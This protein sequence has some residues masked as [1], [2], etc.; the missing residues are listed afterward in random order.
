M[1]N[2]KLKKWDI[3]AYLENRKK[4]K[5]NIKNGSYSMAI[6]AVMIAIAVVLNLVVSELPSQYREIDLSEAKLYTIGE[7]TKK[8]LSGLSKDVT[9]YH[10]V[11]SGNESNDLTNLLERYQDSSSHIKV[12]TKD[13]AL[14]PNFSAQY[15]EEKAVD[16][17]IIVVCGDRSKFISYESLYESEVDYN[18]YSY[19]TTGFDGEG[20]ITSAIDYVVSE[21][22]P[23]MYVLEGHGEA[24]MSETL[25][26]LIQKQNINIKNLN[27]LTQ[28]GVPEDADCMFIF[29]PTADF[30]KEEADKLLQYFESGGKAI[31]V[32]SYTETELPNFKSILENYGVKPCEGVVIE[33]DSNHFISQNPLYH[34]PEIADH[35]ITSSLTEQGR[36][37]L[38]P[39]AQGIQ[40]LENYRDTLTIE[41]LLV[42]SDEAYSKVNIND[43]ATMEKEEGDID[44]PFSLGVAV[45]EAVGEE[46]ETQIAYFS[47]ESLLNDE[48]NQMV[49]GGNY[50]LFS[51][52]LS[53]MC[54]N[55][56]SV[57]IPVKDMNVSYLT[58]PA[59]DVSIWSIVTIAILPI[60]ILLIGGVIWFRRRKQ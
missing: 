53:W 45:T 56:Q 13:P 27:L 23:N 12:E 15:T 50:E 31:I 6:S 40:R 10:V 43:L 26:S 42:T 21:D 9:I 32:S 19:K 60:G 11:Q 38:M 49:S 14:N 17:S 2:K 7:Q 48:T 46:N 3:K 57:S 39:L 36:Y 24:T 1:K 44:G 59:S 20:Q 41:D 16:N 4:N 58:I 35:E 29:A 18:T 30:S 33:T 34:L 22:L 8:L 28:D 54:E 25:K 5:K 55:E 37:V 47:S 51:A 52:S